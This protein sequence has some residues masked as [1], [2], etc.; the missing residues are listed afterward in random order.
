MIPTD[1]IIFFRGAIMKL[2]K[3]ILKLSIL[4]A[5]L[6]CAIIAGS[7][8]ASGTTPAEST[9]NLNLMVTTTSEPVTEGG[10]FDV[11][12]KISNESV[13]AFKIAGLEVALSYDSAKITTNDAAVNSSVAADSTVKYKVADNTVKFVCVKNEFTTEEGYTELS[14]LFTVTFT[15]ASNI[16]NPAL[17]FDKSDIKFLIGSTEALAIEG[18]YATYAGDMEALA[19]AILD[20]GLELVAD[21]NVGAMVVVAPTPAANVTK[22]GSGTINGEAVQYKTGSTITVDGKTAQVVVKGDLDGDGLVSVFDATMINKVT[23][24]DA[25]EKAAADL[26]AVDNAQQAVDYVVG[27]ATQI[28][29]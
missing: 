8:F 14:D 3:H 15:A 16:A 11:K 18:Q 9:G 25:L 10:T 17:L 6:A 20:Q 21:A 2:K 22:V 19:M 7:M 24:E 1:I 28:T 23:D 4:A 29:K 27:N 5:V 26:G 12:V 13:A